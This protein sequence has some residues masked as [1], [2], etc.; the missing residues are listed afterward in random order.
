MGLNIVCAPRIGCF[1]GTP[2]LGFKNYVYKL[3]VEVNCAIQFTVVKAPR[4]AN[5]TLLFIHLRHTIDNATVRIVVDL[6][7]NTARKGLKSIL[8]EGR[9]LRFRRLVQIQAISC[10]VFV[11]INQQFD[12]LNVTLVV[13][14]VIDL[15]AILACVCTRWRIR[16]A[17]RNK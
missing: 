4:T 10:T 16:R 12:A 11:A 13:W 6:S 8:N 3:S 5:V 14:D 15:D 9:S 2:K 7:N 1:T 17:R